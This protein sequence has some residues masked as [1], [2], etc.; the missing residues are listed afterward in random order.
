MPFHTI[1]DPGGEEVTPLRCSL[2]SEPSPLE[3]DSPQPIKT[4][5][6]ISDITALANIQ[7]LRFL[8]QYEPLDIVQ[9][10]VFGEGE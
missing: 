3:D 5:A 4:L 2:P 1:R 9:S 6:G 8:V 7:Q 10:A